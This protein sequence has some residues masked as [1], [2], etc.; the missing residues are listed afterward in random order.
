[1][2]QWEAYV[3]HMQRTTEG[4]REVKLRQAYYK[5]VADLVLFRFFSLLLTYRIGEFIIYSIR[6]R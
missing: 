1:M 5:V 6:P 2:F 4:N 3:K